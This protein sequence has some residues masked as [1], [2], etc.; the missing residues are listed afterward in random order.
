MRTD[1]ELLAGAARGDGDAFAAF[2][3]RHEAVVTRFAIRRCG[4]ADDVADAVA[5]TFLVALRRADALRPRIDALPRRDRE[6]LELVAYADLEPHEAAAALGISANAARL[7]LARARRRL[8]EG[9][10]SRCADHPREP[11]S[12]PPRER[13]GAPPS[14]A[15]EPVELRHDA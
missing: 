8:G 1:G 7:R 12:R 6:V 15:A 11:C 3:R 5:D 2:F 4:T 10:P 14:P 13:S 9:E